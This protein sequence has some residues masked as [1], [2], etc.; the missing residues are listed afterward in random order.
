MMDYPI[1]ASSYAAEIDNLIILI[2]VLVGFWSVVTYGI[3][4]WLLAAYRARGGAQRAEHLSGD[5]K[6]PKKFITYAHFLVLICDVFIV[7]GAIRVWVDVKQT[8]PE[9]ENVQT[10]RVISQQWA[11]SFVHPGPDGLLDTADDIKSVDELHIE[12]GRPYI[13]E[14]TSRDVLHSFSVPVFRL[15]QDAVPGRVI[16]GWFKATRRGNFDIQC[17][18]M[19]GIGHG[20]MPARI[21]IESEE[22]HAA[23]MA[24]QRAAQTAERRAPGRVGPALA[25][26]ASA[27]AGFPGRSNNTRAN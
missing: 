20:L 12:V 26:A 13:Y 21:V 18:E 3:F 14:L 8:L 22:Q 6:Q 7:W 27:P 23:W 2:G 10:V 11:W 1:Q 24:Q 9:G 5:E 16:R 25:S 15:K 17:A 19:C 4:F